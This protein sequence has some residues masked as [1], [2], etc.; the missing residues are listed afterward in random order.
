MSCLP[1]NRSSSNLGIQGKLNRRK[2]VIMNRKRC[3]VEQIIHKP[4]KD[5]CRQA[6]HGVYTLRS[7]TGVTATVPEAIKPCGR[8]PG[9]RP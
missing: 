8:A 7:H 9:L 3:I 1:L 4:R 2:G 5:A 6:A